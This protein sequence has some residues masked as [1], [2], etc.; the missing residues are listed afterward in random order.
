MSSPLT[1]AYP[2]KTCGSRSLAAPVALSLAIDN[3]DRL[4]FD[5]EWFACIAIHV[6]RLPM[7][8]RWS[9]RR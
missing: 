1:G 9:R 7:M 8:S 2:V 5:Q 6:S 4:D 3:G